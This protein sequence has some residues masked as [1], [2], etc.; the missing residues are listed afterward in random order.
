MI[1]YTINVVEKP[2]QRFIELGSHS[3]HS[4]YNIA[5]AKAEGVSSG[6]LHYGRNYEDMSTRFKVGTL[7]RAVSL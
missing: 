3:T 2:P 1:R 4:K 7:Q 5:M 6:V